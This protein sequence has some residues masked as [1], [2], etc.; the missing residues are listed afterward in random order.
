[1]K[2]FLPSPLI[3]SLLFFTALLGIVVFFSLDVISCTNTSAAKTNFRLHVLAFSTINYLYA[4]TLPSTVSTGIPY[5]FLYT[6]AIAAHIILTDRTLARSHPKSFR[7]KTRW[8]FIISIVLGIFHAYMFHP[9]SD[10]TLA[11]TTA[12]LGGGVLLTVF[13]EEMPKASMTQLPWFLSGV[14]SMSFMLF[15]TILLGHY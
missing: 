14:F 15:S 1:M 11:I 10:L 12:F 3:E 2:E 5:S 9:L 6:L 13:R 4:Y 8:I 7:A